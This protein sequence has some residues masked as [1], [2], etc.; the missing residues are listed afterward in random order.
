[1]YHCEGW[2][3]VQNTW[4][5]STCKLLKKILTEILKISQVT[6]TFSNIYVH[7]HVPVHCVNPPCYL[8]ASRLLGKGYHHLEILKSLLLMKV[9]VVVCNRGKQI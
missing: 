7:T 3:E 8:K 4:T 5:K 6:G 9:P 1:M 2:N